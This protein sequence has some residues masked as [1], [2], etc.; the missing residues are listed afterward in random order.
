MSDAKKRDVE[1]NKK[2][3]RKLWA[4]TPESAKDIYRLCLKNIRNVFR[5]KDKFKDRWLDVC[6]TARRRKTTS[7]S[8]MLKA[9]KLLRHPNNGYRVRLF[10]VHAGKVGSVWVIDY[11]HSFQL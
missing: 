8:D 2:N 6:S 11:Y 5:G 10:K 1:K 4:A 7:E 9:V 3:Y